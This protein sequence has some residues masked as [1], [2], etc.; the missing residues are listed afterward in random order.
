MKKSRPAAHDVK[1]HSSVPRDAM[2]E[3]L[4]LEQETSPDPPHT[5]IK[6]VDPNRDRA[7]GDADRTGRHFDELPIPGEHFYRFPFF[8]FTA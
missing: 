4:E 1:R 2:N 3:V 7:L 6:Y 8:R 5:E